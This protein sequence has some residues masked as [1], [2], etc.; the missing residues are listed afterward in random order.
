MTISLF[1]FWLINKVRQLELVAFN[2]RV[3]C[4]TTQGFALASRVLLWSPAKLTLIL[5]L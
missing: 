3:K 4:F 5:V 1:K 2:Q